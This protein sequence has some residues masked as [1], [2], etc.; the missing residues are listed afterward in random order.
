MY[1]APHVMTESDRDRG[2]DPRTDLVFHLFRETGAS[3]DEVVERTTL[4]MDSRWKRAMLA[5]VRDPR[6][7]LD[8]ASGTGIVT[9]KIAEKWPA[10]RVTGVELQPEYCRIAVERAAERGLAGRVELVCS[11][12]EDAPLEPGA[13]DHV[14]S[15]YLPKYADLGR[16]VPR[17]HAALAP[18]GRIILHDFTYPQDPRALAEWTAAFERFAREAEAQSPE[19]VTIFRELPDIVR[20]STW[21]PDLERELARCGFRE[22]A[23]ES[24]SMGCAAIV[25][26]RR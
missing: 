5:H 2:R 3:Y 8:L 15:S 16:L 6:R 25:T 4:G 10:C 26:A 12:A 11:R 21:V 13:Y 18:G 1:H 23:V 14:I 9:F 20:R 22:I 17:L 24:L 7:V 19:W